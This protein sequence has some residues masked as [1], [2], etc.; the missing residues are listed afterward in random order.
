METVYQRWLEMEVPA[1]VGGDRAVPMWTWPVVMSG[2]RAIVTFLYRPLPGA[3]AMGVVGRVGPRTVIVELSAEGEAAVWKP[4]LGYPAP[5]IFHAN[6]A[7][8]LVGFDL[9]KKGKVYACRVDGTHLW[10]ME[11]RLKMGNLVAPEGFEREAERVRFLREDGKWMEGRVA[12]GAVEDLKEG[13]APAGGKEAHFPSTHVTRDGSLWVFE[14]D[15]M[16][17]VTRMRWVR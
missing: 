11:A 7:D 9:V 1:E 2:G 8:E 10:T 4:G 13:G 3:G 15:P 5:V 12:N 14:F 16:P 17:R 6:D